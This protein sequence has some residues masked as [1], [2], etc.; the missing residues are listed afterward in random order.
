MLLKTRTSFT[1]KVLIVGII[2][3]ISS[4]I[5]GMLGV[6]ET[7]FF[8]SLIQIVSL[9]LPIETLYTE[10]KKQRRLKGTKEGLY[11][12][13][14]IIFVNVFIIVYNV[15]STVMYFVNKPLA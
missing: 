10:Y 3:I 4:A 14:I 13:M 2:S 5:L 6:K 7:N 11:Y 1:K 8:I 15:Y 12:G 9:A